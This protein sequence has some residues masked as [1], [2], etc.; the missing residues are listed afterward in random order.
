MSKTI[1]LNERVIKMNVADFEILDNYNRRGKT[2][3]LRVKLFDE[4]D[5]NINSYGLIGITIKSDKLFNSI[6][7][8]EYGKINLNQEEIEL[9]E[10]KIKASNAYQRAIK[11]YNKNS[12]SLG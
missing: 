10:S 5:E 6:L 8:Y 12:S 2:V 3:T 7:S 11:S 1:I 9:L 4:K